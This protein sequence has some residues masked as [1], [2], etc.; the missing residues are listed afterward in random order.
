MTVPNEDLAEA[1]GDLLRRYPVREAV[2]E[3][4]AWW[5]GPAK[6][7]P[8]VLKRVEKVGKAVARFLEER[9]VRVKRPL[10]YHPRAWRG[11]PP[12]WRQR[13]TGLSKPSEDDVGFAL[14]GLVQGGQVGLR[15]KPT[16]EQV[17]AVGL[18]LLPWLVHKEE[19][20]GE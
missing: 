5:V 16:R 19:G 8:K 4:T 10:A 14:D 20:K 7:A 17:D 3:R 18:A 12:G 6:V 1:L 2:V 9:G 11:E 13:F 15:E